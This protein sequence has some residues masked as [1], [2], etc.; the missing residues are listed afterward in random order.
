MPEFDDPDASH[1]SKSTVQS[2]QQ[3]GIEV[4]NLRRGPVSDQHMVSPEMN[5]SHG[6]NSRRQT[7]V[8]NN[9]GPMR[10]V[11]EQ[12]EEEEEYDYENE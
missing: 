7:S 12:I 2:H 5:L 4:R 10:Q 3:P 8:F 1:L 11:P 6:R 9:I